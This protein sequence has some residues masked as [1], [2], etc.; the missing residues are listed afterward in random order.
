MI[1]YLNIFLLLLLINIYQSNNINDLYD[2]KAKN[3]TICDLK[4]STD[5]IIIFDKCIL[6]N[7]WKLYYDKVTSQNALEVY[8]NEKTKRRIFNFDYIIDNH[9]SQQDIIIQNITIKAYNNKKFINNI[10]ISISNKFPIF[11]KKGDNFD[12]IIEYENYNYLYI[13]LIISVFLKDN[14]NSKIVDLNFGYRKIVS[15]EFNTKINLSYF[16][17]II[18]FIII[19]FLLRLR[20][21][22]TDNQFIGYSINY[23]IIFYDY[24]IY[25][26]YYICFFYFISNYISKIIF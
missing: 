8:E 11:L 22:I 7:E 24:K 3:N 16:F 19:I 10:N 26:L 14:I 17:L 6:S 25:I 2:L 18:F 15:N 23:S 20:L 5:N 4:I 13:N 9:K 21:L 1:N 12:V